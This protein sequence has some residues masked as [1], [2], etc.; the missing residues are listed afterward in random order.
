MEIEQE[1]KLDTLP[2]LLRHHYQQRPDK[3]AMR[4]KDRGIW[5]S[6][7]WKYY[8]EKVKYFALG[9]KS[10]GLERGEKISVIGENKPE[11]YIAELAAV[12]I[13]G[14]ALG[15]YPDSIPSEVKYY[16]EHSDSVFVVAHDQE[17][18]DKLLDLKEELP[19][20]KKVIYWD[21][22][23]LW[24]YQDPIL[25]NFDEVLELGR[26]Y[27]ASD[28]QFFDKS[29]DQGHE[30]DIAV[31]CYTSGTTGVPKGAMGSHHW[32]VGV[33]KEWSKMDGWMDENYEYL[34]FISPTWG[35]EQLVGISGSLVANMTVNFPEEPETVQEDSREIGP[36]LIFYGARLFEILNRTIQAKMMDS[37]LPRRL[38]YKI[39]LPIG[40]KVAR[41]QSER[42]KANLIWRILYF[43]AFHAFFRQLR[44][45][46]GLSKVKR[47]YSAG[48]AV[49]P[50]IILF[51]LALGVEI[52]L[53]YGTTETG[54]MNTLAPTGKVRA[55]TSGQPVP[56]T[57][58]KLTDEGEILV[59]SKYMYSG[60]YKNPE[61][62]REKI[63]DGWYRTSDFGYID[64]EGDLIV[65]DR[66]EDLK[67]LAGGKQFSPQFSEIRLRFSPYIK[68]VLVVGEEKRDYAVALINIDME[69]VG[70][71]AEKNHIPYT[72][73]TD[74]SQKADVIELVRKE[75]AKVNRALPDYARIKKFVNLHKEFDVDEAEMTRTRKLRR[76]FVEDRYA[77]LIEAI[78]SERE[79][80]E[81]EVTVAYRDGRKGVIRTS[82]I[83]KHV[84]EE[85]K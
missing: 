44:D 59:K 76:S 74:L 67:P 1:T 45:N 39:C 38:I 49:S 25:L 5:K 56:W 43:L 31:I 58:I 19:S 78:Y 71:F 65:I 29:I 12:S 47:V 26:E 84:E 73:F 41:M 4:H 6:Y 68:D 18:V 72:T 63:M 42:K 3:V 51:F 70:R 14:V 61:A 81:V 83:I 46:I 9:L 7:T 62:T 79:M 23:G 11:W 40:L 77:D 57:D 54:G 53:F 85:K 69:N 48:A 28:P 52:K 27:E 2:R 15:I 8:Y 64:E 75:V 50:D 17:Q 32:M 22:K 20:V 55:E 60:Y 34:S 82:I 37:T 13:G 36:N 10:L 80:Y 35:A 21:P 30:D 33:V 16:V 24:S 66:M